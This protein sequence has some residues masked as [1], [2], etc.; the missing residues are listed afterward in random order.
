MTWDPPHRVVLSWHPTV[1]PVAASTIDVRFEA[2]PEGT[3]LRLEHRDWE[4]YGARLGAE[5]R[6]GYEPGWDEVLGAFEARA[7]EARRGVH[8]GP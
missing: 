1:E 2:L 5:L 6:S 8:G 7:G 4:E 3:L